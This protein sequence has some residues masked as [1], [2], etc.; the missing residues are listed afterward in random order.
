MLCMAP[1][2]T[3]LPPAAEAG[4][5]A[6]ARV[7]DVT[8]TAPAPTTRAFLRNL[9]RLVSPIAPDSSAVIPTPSTRDADRP[10]DDGCRRYRPLS[11]T[12]LDVRETWRQSVTARVGLVWLSLAQPLAYAP[13]MAP[14]VVPPAGFQGP[15]T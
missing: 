12:R 14:D 1:Y 4:R 2:A 6:R 7:I 13:P 5:A 11:S 10:P 9:R 3:L 15:S 8:P